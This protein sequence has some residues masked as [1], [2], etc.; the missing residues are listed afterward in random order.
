[1]NLAEA[2]DT[3]DMFY[4]SPMSVISDMLRGFLIAKD[5]HDLIAADFSAIEARVIAWLAGEEKVLDL[6]RKKE[7]IYVHAASG[8][9]G[10]PVGQIT[11]EQRQIGKVAVLALGYQG[12]VGAFQ[13]MAKAYGVTVSDKKA[14]DIKVKWREAHPAIVRYW[15]NLELA[16]ISAV[17]NAGT[18]YSA[19]PKGREIT[20]KKNGSFLWCRLPSSRVLCYPYPQIKQIETPWGAM[21]DGLTYMAVDSVTKKFE[22]QKAYGGLLCENV[23]QAVSRDILAEA[24]FRVETRGYPIVL[25]C[26]DE[27]VCEVPKSFGS[28]E[29]ME[30]IMCELP[31]WAAGLPMAAKGWR[32]HRYKK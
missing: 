23:V 5:G 7:D 10:V 17:M 28:V 1:M 4:G 27:I 24:M 30:N 8:I 19:G 16:A 11:E 3:I 2:R 15:M 20:Y 32:H 6:F 29:E 12:G 26:H 18:A 31:Q 25:H 13:T 9:Y 21:K 22:R 14:D